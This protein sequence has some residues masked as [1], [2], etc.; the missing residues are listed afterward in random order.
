[1]DSVKIK[2]H[3]L[4]DAFE[5][6]SSLAITKLIRNRIK[7][8]ERRIKR[9]DPGDVDLAANLAHEITVL[10]KGLGVFNELITINFRQIFKE[11]G[12]TNEKA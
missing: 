1:M 12:N 4:T 11:D 8:N 6:A 9:L 7:A 5:L 10:E 3:V 2:N